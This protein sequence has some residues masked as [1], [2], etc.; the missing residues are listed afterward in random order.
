MNT[1]INSGK[2][3][4]LLSLLFDDMDRLSSVGNFFHKNRTS[5]SSQLSMYEHA[6]SFFANQNDEETVIKILNALNER[7]LGPSNKILQSI[8]N[9][10][11]FD[12]V[13]NRL[14][15]FKNN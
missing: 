7:K 6:L 10:T 5:P 13:V 9:M 15:I 11:R 1:C 12:L 14:K 3:D 2:R 8:E 4:Q